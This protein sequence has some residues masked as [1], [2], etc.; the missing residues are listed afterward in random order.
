MRLRLAT[1]LVLAS[2]LVAGCSPSV[3]K[4]VITQ[5]TASDVGVK[6][7]RSSEFTEAEK[8]LVMGYVARVAMNSLNPKKVKVGITVAEALKEEAALEKADRK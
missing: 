8:T 7:M 5:D 3:R 2:L 6:V 1:C 4:L